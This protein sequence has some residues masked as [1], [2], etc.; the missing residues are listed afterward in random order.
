MRVL[1]KVIVA[2]A[3][4]AVAPAHAQEE[5]RG[6][7]AP[8]ESDTAARESLLQL[9]EAMFKS[10]NLESACPKLEQ[11]VA[12]APSGEGALLLARCYDQ[13]GKTASAWAAYRQA[14]GMLDE[15]GRAEDAAEASA[16]A[17]ELE[18]K[19]SKLTIAV[20]SPVPGMEVMRD[21]VSFGSGII[22][23]PVAIDPGKHVIE[24]RARG[25]RSWSK[26][27]MVRPN[28]DRMVVAVPPLKVIESAT[29]KKTAEEPAR[30]SS[31]LLPAGIV[32]T[33]AGAASIAVGTVL[34]I[35]AARYVAR[36]EVDPALC[37]NVAKQCTE[38]GFALIGK[39]DDF[40][41]GSSIA[42]GIGAAAVL[43]GVTLLTIEALRG[44]QRVEATA[45]GIRVRF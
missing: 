8:G 26:Q 30:E 20:A 4:L 44:P 6:E 14:A 37:G 32:V 25:H 45:N 36:A 31:P 24:V 27:V 43:G 23:V 33:G 38:E 9:G 39:A 29:P 13:Q 5:E 7:P 10:G 40:A 11:A 16:R 41:L 15:A 42:I 21:G 19:V 2:V 28:G 17:V 12:A 35:M 34:G 22:G 1:V 18:P 3:L